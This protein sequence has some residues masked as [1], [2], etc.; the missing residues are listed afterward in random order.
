MNDVGSEHVERSQIDRMSLDHSAVANEE[1]EF[2]A[3]AKNGDATAFGFLCTRY[4]SMVFNIARRILPTKEDAEDAVQESFQLA[5]VHLSDFRGDSRFSTW[6]TRIVTH[7]A[8]MQ[9]RRNNVRSKLLLDESHETQS[10]SLRLEARDQALDPEQRC[11]QKESHR[12]LHNALSQ[13]SAKTR[14]AIQLRELDERSA[15]EAARLMG[16][17]VNALK[18]RVFH[19]RKK[20]HRLLSRGKSEPVPRNR[21]L[22][23]APKPNATLRSEIT[24]IAAD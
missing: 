20:L 16:I 3:A 6:L 23:I 15:P 1:R 13:L 14:R 17:S 24:C 11:G 21:P 4:G 12:L 7:A 19:G 10:Y 22:R 2:V 18:S 9:M 5:F 8:L